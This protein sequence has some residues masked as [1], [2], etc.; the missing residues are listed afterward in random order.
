ML[1]LRNGEIFRKFNHILILHDIFIVI[2]FT[3]HLLQSVV[4]KMFNG[5]VKIAYMHADLCRYICIYF[6]SVINEIIRRFIN[7]KKMFCGIQ[8]VN[9]LYR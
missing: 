6:M 4:A 1:N 8:I 2:N 3:L 5:I 7:D 9:Y